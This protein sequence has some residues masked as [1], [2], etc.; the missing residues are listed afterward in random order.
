MLLVG[1]R[2]DGVDTLLDAPRFLEVEIGGGGHHVLGKLGHELVMVPVE[3]PR[4]PL[5]VFSVSLGRNL[6]AANAWAKAYVRVEAGAQRPVVGEE[7]VD[8][9]V[10]HLTDEAAPFGARRRANWYDVSYRLHHLLS[11]ATVGVWPEVLG[12]GL[13]LLA[14]VFDRGKRV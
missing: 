3:E 2:V 7:R 10:V 9:A 11:G 8:I 1:K 13:M 4:N 5:D 6:S 12:A 14:G